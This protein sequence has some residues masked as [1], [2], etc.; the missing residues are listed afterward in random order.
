[1][2]VPRMAFAGPRIIAAGIV[3]S[4]GFLF[5]SIPGA[6]SSPLQRLYVANEGSNTISVIDT[7]T[8]RAVAEVPTGMRP[9]YVN[10][11]PL[12]R[13]FYVTIL[14][15]R[16]SDDLVQIFDVKTNALLASVISGHQP[17]HLVPGHAGKR[18][19]V[20]NRA[21]STLS[22]IAIPE[23]KVIQTV[24]LKGRGPRGTVLT[25]DGR[26]ILIPE[27]RSRDVSMVDLEGN[28]IDRISLPSGAKPMAMGISGDGKFAYVTDEGLDQVHRIDVARKAVT[29]S[30]SVGKRPMH[31]PVHPNRPFLYIPC[32][33]SGAVYKVDL[34]RWKVIKIIPVGRSPLGIAYSA[35]G[36]Y[37]YV[38]LSGEKPKGQVAVIDTE[39]DTVQSTFPVDVTPMGIAVLFGKNQGW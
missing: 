27:S 4:A 13:Y 18:L 15:T 14:F 21:A 24:K 9:H 20:S 19:Y 35:D 29:A 17:D 30:L 8:L 25:P 22:I 2:K 1:M 37:A 5:L 34:D 16:E 26:Y 7:E 10:V 36:K 39:T 6:V 11:D 28:H 12:G 3:V 32:M 31:A 38:T 33:G 23:F